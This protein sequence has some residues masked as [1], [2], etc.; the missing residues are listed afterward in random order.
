MAPAEIVF[1]E[2]NVHFQFHFMVFPK[3]PAVV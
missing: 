1:T 3:V 2:N